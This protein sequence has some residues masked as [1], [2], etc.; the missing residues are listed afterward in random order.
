MYVT[1]CPEFLPADKSRFGNK[2]PA[3]SQTSLAWDLV[4]KE[5]TVLMPFGCSSVN[6]MKHDGG[7]EP[8]TALRAPKKFAAKDF[9]NAL[10]RD[11]TICQVRDWV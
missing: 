4:N 5:Y 8:T 3:A 1:N 7:S 10:M 6:G 9:R 2:C 11:C